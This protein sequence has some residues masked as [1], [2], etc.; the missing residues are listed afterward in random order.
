MKRKNMTLPL[1]SAFVL[2]AL[3]VSVSLLFALR[4]NPEQRE[5]R[6][7]QKDEARSISEYEL[8]MFGANDPDVAKT[9]SER[10]SRLFSSGMSYDE[11]SDIRVK[12][13]RELYGT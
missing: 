12:V 10:K 5:F 3:A 2:A 11:F 8:L 6:Q 4:G 1:A 7:W 9:I 13:E